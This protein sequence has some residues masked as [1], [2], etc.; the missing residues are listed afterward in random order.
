MT[1]QG[2]SFQS[3]LKHTPEVVCTPQNFLTKAAEDATLY[4][5]TDQSTSLSHSTTKMK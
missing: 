5:A 3:T 1:V 4:P 2:T